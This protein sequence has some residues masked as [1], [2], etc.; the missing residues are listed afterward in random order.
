MKSILP[1]Q[2]S[3]S[4]ERKKTYYTFEKNVI[5]DRIGEVKLVISKRKR[6]GVTKYIIST[7]KSLSPK[8]VISIYEDRWDIETAH[9]EIN[10]KLGFKD[11][12]LRDKNTIERFI[13][14]VFQYGLQFSSGKWTIHQQKTAQI[15]EQWAR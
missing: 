5:I 3:M 2:L 6:D 12:Q 7:D 9:R 8:E 15:Q 1:R 11:Y 10:Q 14:L 13:Q 4:E